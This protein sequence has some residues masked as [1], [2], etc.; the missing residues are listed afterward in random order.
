MACTR[1]PMDIIRCENERT[2]YRQYRL[3]VKTFHKRV[4]IVQTLLHVTS[5][6]N[7]LYRLSESLFVSLYKVANINSMYTYTNIISCTMDTFGNG[8]A[9][10]TYQS[11]EINDHREQQQQYEFFCMAIILFLS[12]LIA[13]LLGLRRQRDCMDD[14]SSASSKR[15]CARAPLSLLT[16]FPPRGGGEGRAGRWYK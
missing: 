10:G 13:S 14:L 2:L 11:G 3:C 12:S 4:C 16:P 1:W 6:D 5:V 9:N 7:K 8:T 15:T